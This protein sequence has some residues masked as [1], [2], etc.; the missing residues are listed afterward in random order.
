MWPSGTTYITF[1]DV[2]VPVENLIGKENQGFRYIMYNFNHGVTARRPWAT[3]SAAS[4]DAPPLAPVRAQ[5]G[6]PSCASPRGLRASAWRRPCGTR[7]SAR[8]SARS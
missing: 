1:E 3:L 8:R 7:L 4:A 2:K 5:S 6:G